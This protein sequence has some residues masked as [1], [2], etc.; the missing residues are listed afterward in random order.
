MGD[1][2][3]LAGLHTGDGGAD[4]GAVAVLV[5]N[6]VDAFAGGGR[7]GDPPGFLDGVG[8]GLFAVDVMAAPECREDVAGVEAERGGDDDRIKILAVQERAIVR[9]GR[10]GVAADL[11]EL[12]EA[13][14]VDVG[15][16]DDADTGDAEE[17]ADELFA[18]AAGADD[19]DPEGAAVGSRSDLSFHLCFSPGGGLGG[20]CLGGGPGGEA[21]SNGGGGEAL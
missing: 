17:V 2:A 11:I 20:G 15:C 18:A 10:D 5:A 9:V 16:G 19:A 13:R 3:D 14:L 8:H 21:G 4:P 7:R 1:V 12:S 6:L